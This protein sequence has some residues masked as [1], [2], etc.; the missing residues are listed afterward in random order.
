MVV[1][2]AMGGFFSAMP[3]VFQRDQ[4]TPGHVHFDR[5]FGKAQAPGDLALG[6]AMNAAQGENIAHPARQGRY[7]ERHAVEFVAVDCLAL[8]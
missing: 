7:Y 5:A 4:K 1:L 8:G 6:K 2:G 3:K